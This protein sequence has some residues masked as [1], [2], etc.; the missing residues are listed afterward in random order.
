MVRYADKHSKP[1]IVGVNQLD[2]EKANWET[3]IE[4]LKQSFGKN[5]INSIPN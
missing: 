1:L 2:H 4:A 5:R 3:S